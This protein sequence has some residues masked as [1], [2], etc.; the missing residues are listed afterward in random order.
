MRKTR[1]NN[2]ATNKT[3]L[4]P[5]APPPDFTVLIA[6][7]QKQG[8][9]DF[10]LMMLESLTKTPHRQVEPFIPLFRFIHDRDPRFF[11]K[12]AVWYLA[13]GTVRD[14]KHLFVAFLSSSNFDADYREAGLAMLYTLAP[15][16]VERVLSYIKGHKNDEGKYVAGIAPSIPRI[17]RSGVEEYLRQREKNPDH[18]DSVALVARSSLKTLYSSLRIKPSEYAQALLFDGNPPETSRLYSLKLLARET[19][20]TEQARLIV[21]HKVPY[22]VAVSSIKVMTGPVL[23]ALINSMSSQ[24]LINNM[25]SLQKKGAMD[26]PDIKALIDQKLKTAQTDKK[27]SALKS[28]EA[29]KAAG[30]AL[31]AETVH[32]LEQVQDKQ[33]KNMGQIKKRTALLVDASGS[34]DQAIELGKQLASLIAPVCVSDLYVYVFDEIAQPIEAAGKGMSDWEKAF[35]GIT[36]GGWTGCGAPVAALKRRKQVV[37]QIVMVTDQH[38]NR[39]PSFLAALTEYCKELNTQPTLVFVNVA[40]QSGIGHVIADQCRKA[41][42]ETDEWEFK[43]DYYALPTLIPML[44]QGTRVEFLEEIMALPLPKRKQAKEPV[45]AKA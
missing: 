10:R 33:V 4:A 28:R 36:A 1:P 18:F 42:Y 31:D 19:N 30:G 15:F 8:E 24:E 23:A 35:K 3:A 12:L 14:L 38:E 13:H 20:P 37:D 17:V 41:G 6:Q 7:A 43:G 39:N 45:G 29:V 44:A 22:R 11:G 34:M 32:A 27:V 40:G 21:E 5:K 26:N 25:A 9:V 16:E 2:P